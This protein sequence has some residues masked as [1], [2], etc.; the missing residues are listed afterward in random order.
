MVVIAGIRGGTGLF[1]RQVLRARAIARGLL[2]LA[3]PSGWRRWLLRA[4]E[5]MTERPWPDDYPPGDTWY[6]VA[7]VVLAAALFVGAGSLNSLTRRLAGE[8]SLGTGV[9]L[10]E[11]LNEALTGVTPSEEGLTALMA[12]VA[13]IGVGIGLVFFVFVAAY[14][15]GAMLEGWWG[16]VALTSATA[17]ALLGTVAGWRGF[18]AA[19]TTIQPSADCS[20]AGWHCR[21]RLSLGCSFSFRRQRPSGSCS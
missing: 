11:R 10:F 19:T 15:A 14:L 6:G 16:R 5:D 20:Q 4:R 7:G 12:A 21:S 2:D 9:R 3:T 8:E 13:F 18:I 17:A 1:P